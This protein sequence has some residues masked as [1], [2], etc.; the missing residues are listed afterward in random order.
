MISNENV[1]T[2][3]QLC[4]DLLCSHFTSQVK[5][6]ILVNFQD[7]VLSPDFLQKCS[8]KWIEDWIKSDELNCSEVRKMLSA[9][10]YFPI[11]CSKYLMIFNAFIFL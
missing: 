5:Q 2:I 11:K 1:L 8:T 4:E 6:Y 10:Y 9:I 7:L 3:Y